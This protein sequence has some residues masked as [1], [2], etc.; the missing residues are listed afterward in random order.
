MAACAR[1]GS[2]RAYSPAATPPPSPSATEVAQA[3]VQ[4]GFEQLHLSRL[5]CLI[6]PQNRA[7]A[8]VAKKIGMRCKAGTGWSKP[9]KGRVERMIEAGL[10]MPAGL[11]KIEAAQQHGSWNALDA[12]AALDVPPDLESTCHSRHGETLLGRI[13]SLG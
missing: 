9:N 13:S 11:A 1:S 12:V 8:A 2:R 3:L 4:Y 7:S 5:I 6:D 10:M